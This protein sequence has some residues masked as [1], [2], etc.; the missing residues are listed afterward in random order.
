MKVITLIKAKS[1]V[2]NTCNALAAREDRKP[3]YGRLGRRHF[4]L[5]LT[6]W[7]HNVKRVILNMTCDCWCSCIYSS[8]VKTRKNIWESHVI[9]SSCITQSETLALSLRLWRHN[10]KLNPRCR[11]PSR[12]Y[13]FTFCFNQLR[14]VLGCSS[15]LTELTWWKIFNY[16]QYVLDIFGRVL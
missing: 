15:P 11:R 1:N 2:F 7:R 13:F 5:S 3:K 12:Q 4:G 9:Y 6:L 10:V 16:L 14:V 8:L